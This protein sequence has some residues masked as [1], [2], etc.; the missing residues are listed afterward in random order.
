MKTILFDSK[1]NKS[2]TFE[3]PK[4]ILSTVDSKLLSTAV[5]VHLINNRQGTQSAKTR[6][7][8]RGKAK[9]PY[10]QKGTGQARQGS[11]K[12][13]HYKGGGVAFAP[14]PRNYHAKLLTKVNRKAIQVALKSKANNNKVYV[15]ESFE[16]NTDL[17]LTKQISTFLKNTNLEGSILM[18]VNGMEPKFK[19][20]A[21]NIKNLKVKSYKDLDAYSIIRNQIVLIDKSAL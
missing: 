17:K 15:F 19:M 6:S 1:G 18:A 9:K 21:K 7:E 16:V 14:K 4:E 13:P 8:V 5:R 12:G 3:L 20:A 10:A 11:R 2:G